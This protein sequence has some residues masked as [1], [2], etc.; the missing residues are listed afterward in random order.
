[1]IPGEYRL[2]E[3]P[4]TINE[5]RRTV[6]IRVANQ[7]DR[8]VQTGSHFHFFE[9]NRNLSFDRKQAVG[10]RLNISSGSAV[11]FEP[12]EE[13]EVELVEIGGKKEVYGLNGLT[14]GTV[15]DPEQLAADAEK[16]GFGGER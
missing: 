3:E 2:K 5:N 9:V 4:V 1:M 15:N 10:M 16:K 13:R 12:G 11:R 7:G 6:T 14:N 8:P